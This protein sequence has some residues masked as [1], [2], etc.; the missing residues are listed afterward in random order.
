M[1]AKSTLMLLM[2]IAV[3][4]FS[5]DAPSGCVVNG[6]VKKNLMVQEK[7]V[8][9]DIALRRKILLKQTDVID[10]NWLHSLNPKVKN[11][12]G[13]MI[14][15]STKQHGIASFVG[16]PKSD[17]SQTYLLWGFDLEDTTGK[18]F[19]LKKF[20]VKNKRP[21]QLKI[22]PKKILLNPFKFELYLSDDQE[23][24]LYPLLLAQP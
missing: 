21:L 6:V 3:I 14:W 13:R 4:A 12:H 10:V 8:A 16:L 22:S 11:V 23:D 24:D 7:L 18:P 17:A 19:L 5:V 2:M 9:N 15:S 20:K 1:W